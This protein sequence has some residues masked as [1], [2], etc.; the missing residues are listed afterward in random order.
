MGVDKKKD[1]QLALS[2]FFKE[3]KA[4]FFLFDE[5]NM[6]ITGSEITISEEKAIQIQSFLSDSPDF[7]TEVPIAISNQV[8]DCFTR[9]IDEGFDKETEYEIPIIASKITV[10]GWECNNCTFICESSPR[11]FTLN[12]SDQGSLLE[13]RTWFA[14]EEMFTF[15]L[16]RGAYYLKGNQPKE[17]TD[18]LAFCDHGNFLIETK[19]L[20]STGDYYKKP[21]ERKITCVKKGIS[22]AIKQLKGAINTVKYNGDIFKSTGE[23]LVFGRS[24]DPHCIILVS[25]IYP[26]E[27]WDDIVDELI[28]ATTE[29]GAHF[30]LFDYKNFMRLLYGCKNNPIIF[31]NNLINLDIE[32]LQNK[33]I[34]TELTYPN[35]SSRGNL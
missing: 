29:T 14:L 17:V 22:K 23:Q 31:I 2:Q 8:L 28:K 3:R 6:N 5:M 4:L 18:I 26:I 13:A 10:S 15:A 20:K 12:D 16:H 32:F 35:N 30:N 9:S 21:M 1:F 27:S 34:H 25:E 33:N 24:L 7:E 19:A 11:T